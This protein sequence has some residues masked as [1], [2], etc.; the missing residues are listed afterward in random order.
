[1]KFWLSLAL[2]ISLW[3]STPSLGLEPVHPGLIGLLGLDNTSAPPEK[4][5]KFPLIS[6]RAAPQRSSEIIA[7]LSEFSQVESHEWSYENPALAVFGYA[8]GGGGYWYKIRLT[9]P[10]RYGWINAR[11]IFKFHPISSLLTHSLSY[12]TGTWDRVVY[13]DPHSSTSGTTLA[14]TDQQIPVEVASSANID[15]ALWLLVV[16]LAESPCVSERTP[17]VIGSGWVPVANPKGQLNAWFFS[18]GC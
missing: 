1:M 2:L 7:E 15:G 14:V 13:A 3:P 11:T 17:A 5:N 4:Y 8:H 18:R 6:V 12:L 9:H 10:E 16:V